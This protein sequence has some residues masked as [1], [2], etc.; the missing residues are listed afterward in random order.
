MD[1]SQILALY[2]QDQR[3]E[4]EFPGLRR[5]VTPHVVRHISLSGLGGGLVSYSQITAAN[6]QDVIQEQVRYF[7]RIGQDFE[8]KLYDHD[9]PSDLKD[10]LRS[11]GFTIEDAEAIMVLDLH[12]APERLR[13]PVRHAIRRI[14]DP[15]A[16]V[17]VQTVR[18]Q[19]WD[20]DPSGL[21]DYLGGAL[22]QAPDQMS[23]YVAYIG[24]QPA[25]AAWIQ[26]PERSL[27]AGLWGGSTVPGFR[28]QGLY[29]ALVAVR[30]QEALARQVRYLT[31]DAL[32]TS[33]P[34]LEK[35]GF[36]TI[37]ISYPCKWTRSR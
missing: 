27:F 15:A 34:I 26:F 2:D 22:I 11:Q 24:Q 13:Q 17:D 10:R 6:A 14:T 32:P 29:T 35:L 8:W 20:Q 7:E 31:V 25:S 18:Q 21:V 28:Q 1:R 19:V 23:V 4:I 37:A 30:A 36:E 33:R 9:Q 3:Q 12:D 16:L 5:E